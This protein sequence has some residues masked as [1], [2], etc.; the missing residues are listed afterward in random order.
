[1]NYKN[2]TIAGGGVLGAQIAFQSAFHGFAVTVYDINDEALQKTQSSFERLQKA[3]MADLNATEEQVTN[4][5]NRISTTTDLKESVKN[6]DFVIESVP[7][8][9]EI[10]T[11]F[12][13]KLGEVAPAKT[14]FASNSSTL[15]PSQFAEATG[16]PSQFLALHFA[17]EIWKH[18]TAEIMG[19]AGTDQEHFNDVVEFAKAIGMVA[20]P[21]Y[22]EQPGYIVNSLLVPFLNN[23]LELW[24]NEVADFEIIDKTWML[25]TGSPTGPFA[26]M[27]VIGINTA[28]H[29][30]QAQADK[31]KNPLHVK[32]AEKLKKMVEAG[33]TG[34]A[35]GKGFYTYPNPAYKEKDFLKK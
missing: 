15:I 12:Y 17:N 10:K 34:V 29:V 22:K 14:V 32:I 19:H 30:N 18:N 20:L 1:M 8:N 23:G 2:I 28:Y 7:E 31:T 16:R 5:V 21:V 3:F 25:G 33:E 24:A 35:A 11:D 26:M 27:D 6:A 4:A 9:V 13:K